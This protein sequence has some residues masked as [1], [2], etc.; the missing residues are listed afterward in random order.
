MA[1]SFRGWLVTQQQRADKIGAF[2]RELSA[3]PNAPN[4]T[5]V[6]EYHEYLTLH[7]WPDASH[8]ALADA[9]QEWWEQT[10][11]PTGHM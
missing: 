7:G 1:S 9:F 5:D 10:F 8:Q 2:A 6:N 3:D 4:A 11:S